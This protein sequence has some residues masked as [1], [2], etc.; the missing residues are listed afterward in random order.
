MENAS[1]ALLIAGA[2]LIAIL[3]IGIAM[4][5]FGNINGMVE[6][7]GQQGDQMQI[8]AFNRPFEQYAGDRVSGSNVKV[9]LTNI[10]SS[11]ATYADD[12]SKQ[13]GA[14][15]AAQ[16][17]ASG[18]TVTGTNLVTGTNSGNVITLTTSQNIGANFKY[19]VKFSKDKSGFING[20]FI[21]RI[22]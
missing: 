20:V 9:L 16:L 7:A 10:N 13:I 18:V 14:A 12:A 5:V 15:T 11:N 17:T 19:I 22:N 2:I 3:L 21:Q 8:Q 4:M 6:T 1:K